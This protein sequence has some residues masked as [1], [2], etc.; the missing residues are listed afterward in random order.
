MNYQN[1]GRKIRILAIVIAC[2]ESL[3]AFIWGYN[4]GS[5]DFE[6]AGAFFIALLIGA[7][8]I[9]VAWALSLPLYGFGIL[10]D[11]VEG[12]FQDS[13]EKPTQEERNKSEE[14][15]PQEDADDEEDF[16]KFKEKVGEALEEI[17]FSDPK[18][19]Q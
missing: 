5:Y 10:V 2:V 11:N 15:E 18:G 16:E 17:I 6:E 12:K 19:K 1:V 7:A 3:G 14:S 9:V 4:I 13:S 8:G